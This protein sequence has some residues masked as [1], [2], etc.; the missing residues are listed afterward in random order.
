MNQGKKEGW[1]SIVREIKNRF[2]YIFSYG[3]SQVLSSI[4]PAVK[5]AAAPELHVI[6]DFSKRRLTGQGQQLIGQWMNEA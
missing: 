2:M 1:A 6:R 4:T 3:L 5:P